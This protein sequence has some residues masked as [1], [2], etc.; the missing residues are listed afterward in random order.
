MTPENATFAAAIVDNVKFELQADPASALTT[1]EDGIAKEAAKTRVVV[2]ALANGSKDVDDMLLVM[3]SLL[4]A[5]DKPDDLDPITTLC[6]AIPVDGLSDHTLTAQGRISLS[7]FT[8]TYRDIGM[9]VAGHELGHWVSANMR[10]MGLALKGAPNYLA[11]LNC[12]ANRN[13][14]VLAPRVLDYYDNTIWSE[15]DWADHYSALV[16]NEMA[17]SPTSWARFSKN[18]GCALVSDD[19]D[20]YSGNHMESAVGDSHSSG[21]YRVLMIGLDRGQLTP[22]CQKFVTYAPA[23]GRNLRCN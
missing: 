8:V 12:V 7:W 18:T 5:D 14:F 20:I 6:R 1:L 10:M 15:E 2:D 19:G 17:K 16:L 23:N 4:V 13:P 9:G 3:A 21:F 11:S 22:S